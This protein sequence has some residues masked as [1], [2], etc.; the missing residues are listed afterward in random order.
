MSHLLVAIIL[1]SLLA[2]LLGGLFRAMTIV[3]F[4]AVAGFFFRHLNALELSLL[5]SVAFFLYM[6]SY[7]ESKQQPPTD[8]PP[9]VA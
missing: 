8:V 2:W 4:V 6:R 1:L 7:K 9:P 5:G 3:L